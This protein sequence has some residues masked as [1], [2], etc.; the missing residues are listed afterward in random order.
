MN[1]MKKLINK[2]GDFNSSD[3]ADIKKAYLF[4]E[5]AHKGQKRLSGDPYFVH[6]YETAMCLID[7][8]TDAK[9]I[10]AGLLHDTVED[11][12]TTE[13]E[14]E[15]EFGKEVLFLVNGVTKL[16]TLKYRGAE[17]HVESLRKLFI[18]T[19]QD[20]RVLIIKLADRL[21][22]IKTLNWHPRKDKQYRIALETIEIYA[23]LASRLGIGQIKGDLEDYA[24]PFV[25]PKEY[26]KVK[27][28]A[29]QKRKLDE[30]YI[31]KIHRSLRAE[32]GKQQIKVTHTNSRVKHLY[33]M[34]KKLQR[35]EMN[36]D[37]IYDIIAVRVVVS[38]IEDCYKTLGIIHGLWTPLPGRI[39]DYIAL[40]KPNGYQSLH[41]T[42]FTGDGGIVEIQV[43][44]DE[45]HK[46]AEY[47]IAS[48]LSYKEKTMFGGFLSSIKNKN[49]K[50]KQ[51]SKKLA[52]IGE[53]L[54]W[55]RSVNETGE[56]IDSLKMDFFKGR[57]F[58]FTPNGDVIDLPEDSTSVDFAY[59]IHSD[60]GNRMFGA[61]VNSKMA[62][63]DTKLI[64]G[65]IVEII[66][67]KNSRPSKKWLDYAET[68]LA[69]RSIKTSLAK[70][71]S[72]Q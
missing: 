25:Y 56:F 34:Y 16:G 42:I 59:A 38:N 26:E 36:I 18:A 46:K 17:R 58:I 41:T 31:K 43:R 35:Y 23:P 50:G 8:N 52:W 71:H 39:K 72:G 55:Q 44:S 12:A 63:L 21:H 66:T 3:L 69:R 11:T 67:R 1:E 64:N 30:K 51:L 33:S 2:L 28:I 57:V 22:N 13:C 65:D 4:A 60:I 53:L 61:K 45:M 32:L 9:T 62:S 48:H 40:P 15:K 6:P 27:N 54:E 5:K 7:L 14:I 70:E 10:M 19:S 20:V 24:F 37:K 68:T 49:T 29:K 47:G